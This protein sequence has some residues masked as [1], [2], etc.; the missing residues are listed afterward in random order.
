MDA[1][2]IKIVPADGQE[3][4]PSEL[5]GAL[6]ALNASVYW[7]GEVSLYP[8][9]EEQLKSDL[10]GLKVILAQWGFTLKDVM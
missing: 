9:T 3:P 8:I 5:A 10:S 2:R 7:V 6:L 4:K 1:V